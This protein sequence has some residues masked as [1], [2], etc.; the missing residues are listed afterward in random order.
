M[1]KHPLWG[2]DTSRW[3]WVQ[4]AQAWSLYA[5]VAAVVFWGAPKIT[6]AVLPSSGVDPAKIV[7][8]PLE[9]LDLDAARSR[10]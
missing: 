8:P 2:V 7:A 10:P 5:V 6:E 1:Q 3:G 9:R 4:H